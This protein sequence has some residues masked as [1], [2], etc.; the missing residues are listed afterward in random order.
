MADTP[1]VAPTFVNNNAPALNADNMN[2]LA[3]AVQRLGVA[4]GGTGATEITEGAIVIGNGTDTIE[5][6]SGTGAVYATTYGQPEF[7]TL[8]P[9][10][11]GT[12]LTSLASLRANLGLIQIRGTAPTDTNSLWIRPSDNTLHYYYK[13]EWR[14]IS[15]TFGSVD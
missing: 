13:G 2:N 1:Y 9:S 3:Q 11:G 7:G 4:N 14:T 12:G 5:E 10:C 6:L 15:G 8:P